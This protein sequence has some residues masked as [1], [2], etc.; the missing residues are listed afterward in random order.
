M[1]SECSHSQGRGQVN[2]IPN[3]TAL[4]KEQPREDCPTRTVTFQDSYDALTQSSSR[5][6][7]PR[8]EPSRLIG[9]QKDPQNQ[10]R[11]RQQQ[12]ADNKPAS[13][14]IDFRDKIN[15]GKRTREAVEQSNSTT[16]TTAPAV[17]PTQPE[18]RR[19]R[20]TKELLTSA[21][22]QQLDITA[23][24]AVRLWREVPAT[25]EEANPLR[26]TKL[27]R[28]KGTQLRSAGL[29]RLQ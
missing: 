14:P 23:R 24:D 28:E 1:A 25:T 12:R 29:R 18:A 9:F 2:S 19:Q 21:E 8:S 11:Q 7:P 3:N 17:S 15:A 20:K 22:T 6:E 4:S 27:L 13:A 26:N 10:E 16:T 5:D